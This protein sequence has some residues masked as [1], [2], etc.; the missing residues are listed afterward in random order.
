MGRGEAVRVK[1]GLNQLDTST[2]DIR[3][4]VDPDMTLCRSFLRGWLFPSFC[5]LGSVKKT[6]AKYHMESVILDSEWILYELNLKD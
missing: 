1:M 3:I 5:K 2:E 6:L 4:S